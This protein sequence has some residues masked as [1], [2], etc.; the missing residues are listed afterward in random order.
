MKPT[1]VLFTLLHS[2]FF[3]AQTDSLELKEKELIYPRNILTSGTYSNSNQNKGEPV[4]FINYLRLLDDRDR[5]NL[6]QKVINSRYLL[7]GMDISSFGNPSINYTDLKINQLSDSTVGLLAIGQGTT[8][9]S[10]KFG[11]ENQHKL[12]YKKNRFVGLQFHN[13]YYG[14]LGFIQSTN[15]YIEFEK[16]ISTL[17]ELDEI[18]QYGIENYPVIGVR[19]VNFIKIGLSANFGFDYVIDI[20]NHSFFFF[21]MSINV[22]PIG[23]K[24]KIQDYIK[25]D[26]NQLYTNKTKQ[27]SSEGGVYPSFRVG[28]SF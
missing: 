9:T 24:I 14:L 16:S 2:A 22:E 6:N 15:N 20:S 10:L 18:N 19:K 17:I 5:M 12:R 1:F 3:I 28:V 27:I 13:G 7:V 11:I 23:F 21:G 26:P 4:F 25:N 8:N